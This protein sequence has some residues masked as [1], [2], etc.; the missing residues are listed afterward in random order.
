MKLSDSEVH[1]MRTWSRVR[2]RVRVR[3]RWLRLTLRLRLR[4]KI[5]VRVRVRPKFRVSARCQDRDLWITSWVV[6]NYILDRGRP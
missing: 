4:V 6:G 1:G 2:V 5:T 3:V